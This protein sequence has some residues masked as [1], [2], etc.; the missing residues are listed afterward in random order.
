MVFLLP[1]QYPCLDIYPLY[2]LHNVQLLN[3]LLA[4]PSTSDR[5]RQ[6]VFYALIPNVVEVL[7]VFESLFDSIL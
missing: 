1:T 4:T 6:R 5:S 3:T 7:G 2:L